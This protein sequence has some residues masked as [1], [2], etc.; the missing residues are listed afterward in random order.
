[1][2][3][4]AARRVYLALLCAALLAPAVRA[5]GGRLVVFVV[6][7]QLRYQD[8]LW[9]RDE[10]GPGGIGGA[11]GPAGR[12]PRAA[13]SRH[14]ARETGGRAGPDTHPGRGV[15]E[16]PPGAGKTPRG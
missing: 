9:A 16:P 2:M 10:L 12:T 14:A 8:L 11:G 4:I 6:V 5:Q 3:Q 1:M 7:D 13:P 15:G